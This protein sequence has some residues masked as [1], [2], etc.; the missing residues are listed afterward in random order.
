MFSRAVLKI[1]CSVISVLLVNS[2][3]SVFTVITIITSFDLSGGIS[4]SVEQI[5]KGCFEF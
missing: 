3:F 4:E 5:W 2:F 1:I